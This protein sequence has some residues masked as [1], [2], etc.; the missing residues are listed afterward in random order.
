MAVYFRVE[1]GRMEFMVSCYDRCSIGIFV[2]TQMEGKGQT[3]VQKSRSFLRLRWSVFH[4]S[5]EPE[6]SWHSQNDGVF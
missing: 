1:Y 2:V 4:R 5:D 6:L 3:I